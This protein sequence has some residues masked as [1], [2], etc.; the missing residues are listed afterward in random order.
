MPLFGP[1]SKE[2]K[3][4]FFS[5]PLFSLSQSFSLLQT[6]L[7][8]LARQIGG[9]NFKPLI[10][11]LARRCR[12]MQMRDTGAATGGDYLEQWHSRSVYV[13]VCLLRASQGHKLEVC[14]G[15][16]RA[17]N[18]PI[19]PLSVHNKIGRPSALFHCASRSLSPN[20]SSASAGR[21]AANNK[22]RSS[23]A[24][25]EDAP[26]SIALECNEEA[27]SEHIKRR[28]QIARPNGAPAS[29][30]GL[31]ERASLA[32]F[33]GRRRCGL[34]WRLRGGQCTLRASIGQGGDLLTFARS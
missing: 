9:I 12:R 24:R 8:R 15:S 25:L 18:W 21:R 4:F 17:R 23:L 33:N 7:V 2:K 30:F 1:P 26:Q 3:F 13:C 5:S 16:E 14:M 6:G 27:R 11:L 19:W 20:S 29:R 31:A 22:C 34:V 32:P 10:W 28:R